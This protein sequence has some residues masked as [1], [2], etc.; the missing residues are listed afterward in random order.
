RQSRRFRESREDLATHRFPKHLDAP[1]DR[2]GGTAWPAEY[3]SGF[4]RT[5]LS[6]IV[7]SSLHRAENFFRE[8]ASP[9][10]AEGFGEISGF[11]GMTAVQEKPKQVRSI[12]ETC[13]HHLRLEGIELKKGFRHAYQRRSRRK[14]TQSL[15]HCEGHARGH[16]RN[17]QIVKRC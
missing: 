14:Q 12:S 17:F 15:P 9:S 11:R 10:L 2:S 13:H 7:P 1:H 8:F 4:E 5:A 16:F 3:L 6:H